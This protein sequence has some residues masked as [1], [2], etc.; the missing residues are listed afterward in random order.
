MALLVFWFSPARWGKARAGHPSVYCAKVI[1]Q[2]LAMSGK[3]LVLSLISCRFQGIIVHNYNY[4]WL[5]LFNGLNDLQLDGICNA[6]FS[7]RGFR[8]LLQFVYD[9][10]TNYFLIRCLKWAPLNVA[11]DISKVAQ[12]TELYEM[13][14]IIFIF[15]FIATKN[16]ICAFVS[17]F[18]FT[19][20]L[21][22]YFLYDG[23]I[24]IR[25]MVEMQARTI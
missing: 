10:K 20:A 11:L 3:H 4:C 18:L 15:L 25:C 2:R 5:S 22:C 12:S 17:E 24:A 9:T 6:G 8:Y 21:S 14:R 19:Y 1:Q 7:Y 23:Y 13:R 16:Y